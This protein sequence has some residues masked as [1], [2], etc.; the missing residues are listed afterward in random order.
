MTAKPIAVVSTE[1]FVVPDYN[2]EVYTVRNTWIDLY[3]MFD[4]TLFQEFLT[5]I[6]DIIWEQLVV[7]CRPI[8][9]TVAG[10]RRNNHAYPCRPLIQGPSGFQDPPW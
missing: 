10:T 4:L 6:P 5:R 7:L 3:F 1:Y 8:V 9:S 2:S